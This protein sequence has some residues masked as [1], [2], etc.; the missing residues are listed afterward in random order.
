MY[1]R[2]PCNCRVEGMAVVHCNSCVHGEDL[3]FGANPVCSRLILD[4]DGK[5]IGF[6]LSK[7]CFFRNTG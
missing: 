7:A 2:N 4:E 6:T 5:F 3:E 1:L